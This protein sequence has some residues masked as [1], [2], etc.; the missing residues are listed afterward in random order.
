VG[1]G[2]S[3]LNNRAGV[4]VSNNTVRGSL[5]VSGTTGR[6]PAPDTG[7][8]DMKDNVRLR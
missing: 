4:Q 6:L 8:V 2:I 3:L 1:S 7:S 5:I